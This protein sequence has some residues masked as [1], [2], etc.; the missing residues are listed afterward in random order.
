MTTLALNCNHCGAPLKVADAARYVTCAHCGSSLVVKKDSG[1]AWTEL[2]EKIVESQESMSQ[3]LEVL[4]LQNDLERLDREWT[5][6][7]GRY[8]IHGK[9]GSRL[10]DEGGPMLVVAPIAMVVFGVFWIGMASSIGGPSILPVFG[11]VFI[12]AAA[13]SGLSAKKKGGAYRDA[14]QR[15]RR[16]RAELERKIAAARGDRAPGID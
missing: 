12:A 1:A 11:L 6:D 14:R 2:A 15:Y 10:P 13:F 3:D 4:Q 9:Q 5:M 16:R 7:L 8:R